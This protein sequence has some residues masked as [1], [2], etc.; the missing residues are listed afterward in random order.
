MACLAAYNAGHLLGEWIDATQDIEQIR[1]DISNM[2]KNSP[3][4]DAEELA[5][6]DHEGFWGMDIREYEFI[7]QVREK[8]LYIAE[9]G[10]LGVELYKYYQ[11]TEEAT[12]A[13][14]ER[15]HGCFTS[16]AAYAEQ[17]TGETTNTPSH[18]APYIDYGRIA[19]DWKLFGDIFTIVTSQGE[20]HIFCN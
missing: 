16:L 19:H 7:P 12:E 2:L 6:H 15:Y 9:C 14:N 1:E 17:L 18:I 8:A 13:M 4:Q 10:L 3:A 5:I 11:S 20:V